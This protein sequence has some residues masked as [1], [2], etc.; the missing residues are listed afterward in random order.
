LKIAVL[1]WRDSAHPDAGGAEVFVGE[2]GRRWAD[3]GHEIVLFSSLFQGAGTRAADGSLGVSRVG[4]R[5]TGTHH[6]LAPRRVLAWNPD[7]V[8]ESINTVPYLLPWRAQGTPFLPLF[9]QLAVDVWEHHLPRPLSVLARLGERAALNPYRH[10]SVSAVSESTKGDLGRFG[11]NDVEVVPQ[12]GLG[13]RPLERKCGVPTFMFVGRLVK[14]KRPDH[15][16]TAFREIRGHVPEAQLWVVGDGPMKEQLVGTAPPSVNFLG[17]VPRDELLSRMSQA[18]ALLCT[19]VREGWGLVITEANAVGT[20]A[21]AYDIP[22]Y[23][24][25]VH[26]AK[27]GLLTGANPVALAKAAISLVLDP[28]SYESMRSAAIKWGATHTWD[29]TAQFLLD[30]LKKRVCANGA[31]ESISVRP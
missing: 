16:I 21:A 9:H 15:A 10:V 13:R 2:V 18:H 6:L 11:V 22:G 3:M 26:H 30:L 5:S 1:N 14:N 27:T 31:V 20:P 7:V 25:S 4:L 8:L 28:D 19:S 17:R 29:G 12:G 23:R 24:D